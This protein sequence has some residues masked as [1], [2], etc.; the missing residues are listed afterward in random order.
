MDLIE[1]VTTDPPRFVGQSVLR[2]DAPRLLTGRGS[3]VGDR[4]E[5][6]ML[7]MAVVRSPYSHA[8]ITSVD[9][10]AA[11]RLP[12]VAAVLTGRDVAELCRPWRGILQ[13]FAG[14]KSGAQQALADGVVRYVGEPVVAIAA[15]SRYV[16]ED[17]CD[18]VAIDYDP[19]PPVVDPLAALAPGA[20]LVH[21]D[22]EDNRILRSEFSAGDVE[23]AFA[24][25]HRTYRE[26]FRFGRHTG[27]PIETRSLIASFEPA[28][29]ALTVWIS[30]Q[31]PHMMQAVLARLFE[32]DEHRVR[33]IQPDVGGSFGIKIHVY[34]DDM[35]AC[36]L[37]VKLGRP[38]KWIADRRE[39]FLSDIHARDELVECELAVDREGRVTGLQ[40]RVVCPVGSVSAYPRSSVVEGTQ[41]VRLLPGPYQVRDYAY[42]LDVVAQNKVNTS[43]YR[44]V[45]HPIAF[46]VMEGMLDR[47]AADLGIDPAEIRFRNLI[48]PEQMPW[49]SVTGNTYD[50]GSYVESLR[51]LLDK[52]GYE[53]MR[54]EQAEARAAGRYLGIGISC[55]IEITGPGAQFY[56]VGGA[57]I[58]AQ[59][60]TTLRME[61]T[62]KVT[63]LVGLTDQGQGN[64]TAVAQL[65]ADELGI[66]PEDVVVVSGDTGACPY[67]G[68]TWASRGM[69]IA[70]SA[71]LLAARSL[72]EKV[73]GVAA[74]LLE[75][76][77]DDV[78]LVGGEARVRGVPDRVIPLSRVGEAVYY[79]SNLLPAG[80]EPSL[81]ATRHFVNPGPWTF[82]NGAHLALVELNPRTGVVK[83]RRYVVVS[84]CG[85][86]I[87]PALVDGQIRGGIAQGVGGALYEHLPYDE[88]GQLL[89]S[90]L[91]DYLVPTSEEVP[92][93]EVHHVET[94]SPLTVGGF[95]GVGEAGVAGAPAAISNA[96]NDA[97]APF[98]VRV[99]EHPITPDRIRELLR[100]RV[101][102]GPGR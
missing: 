64:A 55:F 67:G 87:N 8:Q 90:T 69:P 66:R 3:Y 37:A 51:V 15:T 46:T 24:N 48:R 59:D 42:S 81:D 70:G 99:S 62:G 57:P 92:A 25:A 101:P 17:A 20:P 102:A 76:G 33:V 34:Q 72:R 10:E 4:T 82:S 47:A 7:H 74:H 84:D 75:A 52:A 96:V 1:R 44:A 2:A 23:G 11:R 21:P 94:P 77:P 85:P 28:T 83:I 97:L 73:V 29:R 45:G 22:L 71:T 79:K 18:L 98:S 5:A 35:A 86:V 40:A 32:L 54:R 89:A 14:M 53:Q 41:V 93:V 39:S 58:S 13:H 78:E 95:K 56:G 26:T 30:T 27:V 12:G 91:L 61:P 65:V 80:A 36:A 16:A 63:A 38:I 6:G 50:S 68:G 49:T 100:D 60:T 31:V 88:D 9:V 43:Q 19:L